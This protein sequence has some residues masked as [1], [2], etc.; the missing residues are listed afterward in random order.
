MNGATNASAAA[1]CA[2]ILL[3]PGCRTAEVSCKEAV[4]ARSERPVHGKP[5][6]PVDAKLEMVGESGADG[7][8][9]FRLSVTSETDFS[10]VTIDI[11]LPENSEAIRGAVSWRGDLEAGRLHEMEV[12]ALIPKI[13]SYRVTADIV[14]LHTARARIKERAVLNVHMG[15][16][17]LPA[18]A[19]KKGHRHKGVPLK[20]FLKKG[21]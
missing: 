10:N 8:T 20:E 16:P 5:R 15:K 13:A 11:K 2:L 18:R 9:T 19:V 17:T 1:L 21:G 14:L 7:R 6:P 4:E 12:T 3:A